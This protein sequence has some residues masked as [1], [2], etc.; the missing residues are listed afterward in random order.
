MP[1][2]VFLK[3]GYLGISRITAA[4]KPHI[5]HRPVSSRYYCRFRRLL[6]C[7]LWSPDHR[8]RRRHSLWPGVF[9][10]AFAAPNI[11]LLYLTYCIIGGIGLGLGYIVALAMLIKWF[12]DRRGFI[13]GLAV[14]GFGAGAAIT[15]PVGCESL[16][17]IGWP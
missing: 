5:Q 4:S 11:Y 6:Q 2:G 14:A 7:T 8:H 9:L 15:G 16:V 17:A 1:G 3:T 13:T 10:A 12:P